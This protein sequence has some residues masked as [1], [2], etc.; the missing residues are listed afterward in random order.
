LKGRFPHLVPTVRATKKQLVMAPKRATSKAVAS[1]HDA[2]KAALL[3]EKK[4]K[5]LTDTPPRGLQ[6][7]RCQQQET[8]SGSPHPRRHCAHLQF[9][10]RTTSTTTRLRSVKGRRHYRGWRIH[11]HLGQRPAEATSFA[12]QKQPPVEAERNPQS[13]APT[14]HHASQGASNDTR[15]GAERSG[16][17]TRDRAH[18]RRRP[19]QPA[20]RT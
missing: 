15:C 18:A 4:G 1:I 3:A 6:R 2:A 16:A 9:R 5:A 8:T 20:A 10:G 7:R 14:T 17:R 12:R 11:Q 19:I 13:Q